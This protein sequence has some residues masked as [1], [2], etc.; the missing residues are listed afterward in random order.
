MSEADRRLPEVGTFS[1]DGS[2]RWDGKFWVPQRTDRLPEEFSMP[3]V[4]NLAAEIPLERLGFRFG[5]VVLAAVAGLVLTFI[6]IPAPDPGSLEGALSELAIVTEIRFLVAFA[7]VV[8][9]LSLGRQGIDVLLLRAMLA[10]FIMGA[11]VTGLFLAAIFL[12]PIPIP[13]TPSAP[14]PLAVIVVG[15]TLAVT[16]GPFLAIFAALANLLWYRSFRSLRPQLGIFN[17]GSRNA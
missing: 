13:V 4:R 10:G 16:L 12:G 3:Y 17:R 7:A 1:A 9:I 11:T 14:W 5:A 8:V 6:P 15:L 2:R